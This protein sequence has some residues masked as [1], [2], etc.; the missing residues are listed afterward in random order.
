LTALVVGAARSGIALANHLVGSGETVRVTDRRPEADVKDAIANMPSG[1]ELR[2]GG[3]ESSVLDGV[4]VVYASPG[5]PWDSQLLQDARARDIRVSSEIDLFLELCAG[6]VVGI[7][8]TNGK[9]TTTALTGEVLRA[10]RRPVLVGGNIGETVLDRIAASMASSESP[11]ILPTAAAASA[12]STLWRPGIGIAG[13]G[14]CWSN[15]TTLPRVRVASAFTTGSWPLSTAKSSG[16]AF[17]I[18]RALRST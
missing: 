7:T 8:G 6:T 11:A 16:P 13:M 9:T 2:L 5:V 3:Y 10:G 12:L 4:D 17:S 14:L 18:A 1:V 15:H